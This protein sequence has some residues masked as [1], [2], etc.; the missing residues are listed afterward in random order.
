MAFV[1]I[2]LIYIYFIFR[3]IFQIKSTPIMR[4]ERILLGIFWLL[5]ETLVY[6]ISIVTDDPCDFC[7][8]PMPVFWFL[9]WLIFVVIDV[10]Y[11]FMML[12]RSKMVSSNI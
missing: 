9:V 6:W 11:Q 1:D 5:L 7:G 3:F 12:S 8:A 4:K 10:V 2:I